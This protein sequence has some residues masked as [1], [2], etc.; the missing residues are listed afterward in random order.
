M[1]SSDLASIGSLSSSS[2]AILVT[3]Y[4]AAPK[5]FFKAKNNDVWADCMYFVFPVTVC[6]LLLTKFDTAFD[7]TFH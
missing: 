4:C 5:D 6:I 1:V 2:Y 7:V 3:L